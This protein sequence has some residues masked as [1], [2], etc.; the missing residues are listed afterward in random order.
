M[1][2]S[3]AA[4]CTRCQDTQGCNVFVFCG[5]K[6][7]CD[8]GSGKVYSQGT[9]TLKRQDLQ[10]QQPTFWAQGPVVKWSSGYIAAA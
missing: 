2:L 4:G 6:A 9:C 10:G 1:C 3:P 5:E 7:G 8:D